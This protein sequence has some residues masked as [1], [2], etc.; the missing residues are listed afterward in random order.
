M[1]PALTMMKSIEVCTASRGKRRVALLTLLQGYR[2]LCATGR[3]LPTTA[4]AA[5][6]SLWQRTVVAW[7]ALI[8]V[9][10]CRATQGYRKT[11]RYGSGFDYDEEYRGLHCF[12]RQAT[13][14]IADTTAGLPHLMRDRQMSTNN[15][16]S[17]SSSNTWNQQSTQS[18]QGRRKC[19]FYLRPPEASQS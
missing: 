12:T 18:T 1:D 19:G 16:S 15:S 9:L 14:S 7:P 4:A 8:A 5:A 17:S 13:S 6:A 3:C 11:A 2:T 10:S